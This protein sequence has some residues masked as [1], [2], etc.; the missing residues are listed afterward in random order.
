MDQENIQT[1]TQTTEQKPI[2][3]KNKFLRFLKWFFITILGLIVLFF[4]IPI[5]LGIIF[6]DIPPI[7]N[8]DLQLPVVIIPDDQNIYFNLVAK[9]EKTGLMNKPKIVFIFTGSSTEQDLKDMVSGKKAW[10]EKVVKEFVFQNEKAFNQLSQVVNKKYFQNP[11]LIDQNKVTDIVIFSDETVLPPVNSFWYFPYFGAVRAHYLIKQNKDKEAFDE[12]FN[13]LRLAQK[14]QDSQLTFLQYFGA[15]TMK[16]RGLD[17]LQTTVA[18]STLTAAELIQYSQEIDE[19]YN[20][21][22]GF[23]KAVKLEY[24]LWI[25]NIDYRMTNKDSSQEI[26]SLPEGY[27]PSFSSFYFHPNEVKL[28]IA[29]MARCELKQTEECMARL[30]EEDSFDE[31]E[32]LEQNNTAA[33]LFKMYTTKNIGGR[34]LFS[35]LME[36]SLIPSW[37]RYMMEKEMKVAQ[38]QAILALKAFKNDTGNLSASLDELTPKYL[39]VTYIEK[40]GKDA[41]KYIPEK[42]IIYTVGTDGKDDGGDPTKDDVY[43]IT[44]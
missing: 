21:R 22:D 44:F 18:S 23:A 15:R 36:P 17:F 12:M 30:R 8:S 24:H 39:P 42:K 27:F 14:I 13:I 6:R 2:K 31:F 7:D 43:Q 5:I 40:V 3:K 28:L 1:S 35:I 38:T 19:F 41:L 20:S 10:D 25:N 16:E 26:P 33:F 29:N 11:N 34:L 32:S 9:D 37:D 4:F